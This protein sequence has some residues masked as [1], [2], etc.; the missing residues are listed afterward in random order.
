MIYIEDISIGSIEVWQLVSGVMQDFGYSTRIIQQ[1]PW[2][3]SFLVE[4]S[5][6]EVGFEFGDAISRESPG[7]RSKFYSPKLHQF[8]KIFS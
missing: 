8:S 1:D 3:L 4:K 2:G 7:S 6:L 5:Y